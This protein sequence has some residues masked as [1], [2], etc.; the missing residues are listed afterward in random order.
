MALLTVQQSTIAG[1]VPTYSAVS[2]SD[3]FPTNG[4]TF[5]YVKNGGASPDTVAIDSVTA[6]NQGA[7]HDGGSVVT[8]A[9]EKCF[10]PFDPGRFMNASGLVTVTHS[11]TT[12]VT[13]AVVSL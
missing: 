5:L 12:S 3:T 6:C 2:A 1:F 8:N 9:T 11:F 7:D 4:K 10:G 13:C